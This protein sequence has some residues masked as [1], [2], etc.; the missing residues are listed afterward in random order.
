MIAHSSCQE[1]S[2]VF[3]P[4]TLLYGDVAVIPGGK[5]PLLQPA[6]VTWN[7]LFKGLLKDKWIQWLADGEAEYTKS[8]KRKS[9]SYEM[10][11]K[12]VSQSWKEISEENIR[13][14]FVN[15]G[16]LRKQG[17]AG[18]YHSRLADILADLPALD[19]ALPSVETVEE[20]TGISDDE[21]FC[22]DECSSEE[23]EH[24]DED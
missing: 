12:W 15:C 4:S 16:I 5:T 17:D 3:L 10:V 18:N 7:K 24:D 1:D 23:S 19:E 2:H 11:V 21:C 6:D 14:S 13:M 8:G 9:A 20:H 22:E